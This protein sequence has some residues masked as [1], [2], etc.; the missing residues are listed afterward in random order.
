MVIR[1]KELFVLAGT[2]DTYLYL[3]F[4]RNVI[5]ALTILTLTNSAVLLPL[6]WTGDVSGNC[7]NTDGDMIYLTQIQ[8]LSLANA[9]N[10]PNRSATSLG[11]SF[12]NTALMAWFI[13]RFKTQI[14]FVVKST[15]SKDDFKDE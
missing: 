3:L 1:D 11:L 5:Y 4:L 10:Q 7:Q 6:Y 12:F 14:D 13:Y 15:K 2:I 9:F 8:Q